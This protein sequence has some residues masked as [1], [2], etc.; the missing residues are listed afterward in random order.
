LNSI[1]S[2]ARLGS[3]IGARPPVAVELSPQGVLAAASPGA[4]KPPVYAFEP[5]PGLHVIGQNTLGENIAD[6][7]GLAIALKAYHISLGGQPAAVLDGLTGDQR[8]FL[9]FG[10]VWCTNQ[11][12]KYSKL[13]VL[14]N[15]HGL[16]KFRVNGP[17]SNIPDFKRAFSCG[18]N[19]PMVNPNPVSVW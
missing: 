11:T 13:Q 8:F 12:E 9:G 14:S 3:Q 2:K 19:T 17:M 16:P 15:P 7:A 4:S 5:L 10:Q 18:D 6:N 1:L